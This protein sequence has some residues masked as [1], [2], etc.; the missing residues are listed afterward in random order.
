MKGATFWRNLTSAL[1]SASFVAANVGY[2]KALE[3]WSNGA[4][5]I[6]IFL[7]I[8]IGG[9]WINDRIEG[10]VNRKYGNPQEN[11]NGMD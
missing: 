9:K 4:E 3:L 2:G 6:L 5:G 8:G 11:E 10:Y 7:G 1:V